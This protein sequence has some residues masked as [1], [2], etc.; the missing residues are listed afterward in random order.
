M[1]KCTTEDTSAFWDLFHRFLRVGAVGK[2][3]NKYDQEITLDY[4]IIDVRSPPQMAQPGT[5][6]KGCGTRGGYHT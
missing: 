1:K 4:L 5:K 3:A 2:R 6:L